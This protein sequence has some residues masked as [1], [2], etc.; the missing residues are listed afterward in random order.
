[1]DAGFMKYLWRGSWV[2]IDVWLYSQRTA[3]GAVLPADVDSGLRP[4]DFRRQQCSE[5]ASCWQSC[6]ATPLLT[7][8]PRGRSGQSRAGSLPYNGVDC[9]QGAERSDQRCLVRSRQH[10]NREG[11]YEG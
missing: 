1:M 9:A 4:A 3:P 7:S 5:L 6:L 2:P 11:K 8:F 10:D